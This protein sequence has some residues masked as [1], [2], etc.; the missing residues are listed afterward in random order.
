LGEIP[1]PEVRRAEQARREKAK[2]D[3][4]RETHIHLFNILLDFLAFGLLRSRLSLRGSSLRNGDFLDLT[5]I[6]GARDVEPAKTTAILGNVKAA[7]DAG[8]AD[9][10]ILL[11]HPRGQSAR[12]GAIAVPLLILEQAGQDLQHHLLILID[13]EPL[14]L[15]VTGQ[16][17]IEF[18]RGHRSR[19]F[20][21][22]SSLNPTI[23]S[24]PIRI[25]GKV[26]LGL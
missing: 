25:V 17:R 9:I 13:L 5:L 22:F 7:I 23:T 2:K 12:T 26:N 19:A 20:F 18:C 16:D 24:S 15:C 3:P 8:T 11:P 4:R 21:T 14:R 10:L 6:P 1:F